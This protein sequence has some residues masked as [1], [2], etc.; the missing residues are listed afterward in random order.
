MRDCI[1]TEYGC[2]NQVENEDYKIGHGYTIRR[3]Y[4]RLRIF[5]LATILQSDL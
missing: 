5:E 4:R 2:D 1:Y 3:G